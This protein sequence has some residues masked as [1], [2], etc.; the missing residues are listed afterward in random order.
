VRLAAIVAGGAAGP[1]RAAGFAVADDRIAFANG[2]IELRGDRP[3]LLGLRIA[4][5]LALPAD[6]EGISVTAGEVVPGADH[7]NGAFELDHVVIV[8][9]L[10][11]RTSAAVES[12]L[13]LPCRR[14]R[15]TEHVRQAFHRFP[16]QGGVRGCIVELVERS[17]V[18]RVALWGLV[19]DVVDLDATVAALGPDLIG[20]PRPAVQPGRRIATIRTAAGL[21]VP[22][23]LMSPS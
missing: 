16:D 2:A 7:P 18:D 11:E 6:I 3:G 17:G 19:V 10:L 4:G 20:D 15:E 9:G 21:G 22:V 23:A 1:W 14:V 5:D 13:G 12:A 8:T